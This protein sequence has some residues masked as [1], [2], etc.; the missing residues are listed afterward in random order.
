MSWFAPSTPGW[1][2]RLGPVPSA[3]GPV[4][5][6]PLRAADGVDWRRMRIRDEALIRP[7]DPSSSLTWVAR[8]TRPAW[9]DHR[10]MLRQAARLGTALP[11]AVT[12]G[13]RFAGQVTIGGIQRFPLHS[14]WVGYWIGSEFAGRG[15]ATVA[16]AQVVAHA[17]TEGALHRVEATVSPANHASQR[18][19]AHLG[20]RQEGLLQ[21]Y[22]D[23]DGGWR[24]HQLWA[25]TAEEATGGA[26][27]LLRSW[28]ADGFAR[29]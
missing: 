10:A 1:P 5:L 27:G 13:G 2:G 29:P 3:L 21:R 12:V 22:L 7:W 9:M 15:V 19:L 17:L 25:L 6:R 11:F 8:H 4:E 23:I 16:V 26:A 28:S 14:G 24:D 18:V 20:F